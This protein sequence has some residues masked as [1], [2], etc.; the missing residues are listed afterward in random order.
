MPT[1]TREELSESVL[2]AFKCIPANL[3]VVDTWGNGTCFF[4]SVALLLLVQNVVQDG[5]VTFVLKLPQTHKLEKEKDKQ[6]LIFTYPYDSTKPFY[7]HFKQV[8]I[9][10][11]ALVC[12][13]LTEQAFNQFLSEAFSQDLK[14]RMED[15]NWMAIKET[16]NYQ[17]QWVD[18]WAIK[19][20]AWLLNLNILFIN[21]S[22]KEQP[23]FCGVE[24]F[25][26]APWT[27]F[28]YWID[29]R[30]FQPIVQFDSQD[31]LK[32]VNRIFPTNHPWI[33][34]IQ[35]QYTGS[36]PGSC[37]ITLTEKQ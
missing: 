37:P 21:A 5:Q 14:E 8:G 7:K 36:Q 22:S 27:L 3:G 26:N 20:T 24:N 10:L 31:S 34:C 9:D 1:F 11:R 30:H 29:K 23:L 28:I 13:S 2:S 12:E 33:Q 4:H 35:K 16:L 25:E 17:Y 32:V 6:Y 19:F 18:V 15:S